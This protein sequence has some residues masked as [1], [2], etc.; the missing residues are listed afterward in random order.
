MVT[1][2][3]GNGNGS[4]RSLTFRSVHISEEKINKDKPRKRHTTID[5]LVLL[6]QSDDLRGVYHV[7]SKDIV[8]STAKNHNSDGDVQ[9]FLLRFFSSLRRFYK[10][11]TVSWQISWQKNGTILSKLPSN[12]PL[13]LSYYNGKLVNV[14]PF[15]I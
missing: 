7:T 10:T 12:H 3:S 14:F 13:I 1:T 4:F 11:M 6:L 5:V 9:L 15:M 8:I 2:T